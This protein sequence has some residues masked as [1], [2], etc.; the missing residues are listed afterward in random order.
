MMP[1][2]PENN[3]LGT[4]THAFKAAYVQAGKAV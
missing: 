4:V 2:W 1:L 3:Q